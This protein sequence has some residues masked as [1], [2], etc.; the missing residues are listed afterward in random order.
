M[1]TSLFTA[2]DRSRSERTVTPRNRTRDMQLL[3]ETLSRTRMQEHLRE[4]ES[5]RLALRLLAA[6]RMQ[7]KAER[8]SLRAR[9][10]LAMAVM[11]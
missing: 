4:A 11:H 10:A 9:R 3:P 2:P 5:E 6:R 8:A 1:S 7:R